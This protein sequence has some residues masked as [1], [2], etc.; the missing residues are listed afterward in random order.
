[1][2]GPTEEV[3]FSWLCAQVLDPLNRYQHVG[4]LETL[5]NTEF[6]WLVPGDKN[7]ADDGLELR[8]AFMTTT[9]L[10]PDASWETTGCSVFEMLIALAQRAEFQTDIPVR[11]WF[12]IFMK[13]LNLDQYRAI[14]NTA[15]PEV[16]ERLQTFVWRTYAPDGR[17]GLFPLQY[18]QRDETQVEL[19]F[20]F[21]EF[22][23]EQKIA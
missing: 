7:R 18:T 6:V 3:Y 12:W 8:L 11:D 19:W 15:I 13:N 20:Q 2:N 1:M 16:I 5:H 10:E 14:S 23:E 17:G 4:L 9:R 22:V 21:C